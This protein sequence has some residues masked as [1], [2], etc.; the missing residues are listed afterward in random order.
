MSAMGACLCG[1]VRLVAGEP[2]QHMHACHCAMCRRQTGLS[3]A[4]DV[5]GAV[6]E[7]EI[8]VH[9]SSDWAERAFCP[10][11]G[12]MLYYR[13]LEG[14]DHSINPFLLRDQSALAV[15]REIFIDEKPAAYALAGDRPRLTGAEVIAE[16]EASTGATEERP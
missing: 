13:L 5:A 10:A 12:T 9:R 4:M 2:T 6:W 11:C 16:Y 1:A 14:G 8:A 7:G 15:A 3:F